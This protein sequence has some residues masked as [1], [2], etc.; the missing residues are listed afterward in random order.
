MLQM[1]IIEIIEII[2]GI[3]LVKKDKYGMLKEGDRH[4]ISRTFS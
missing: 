4:R 2:W 1:E 3:E